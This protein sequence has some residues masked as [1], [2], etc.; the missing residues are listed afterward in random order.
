MVK[1]L[2]NATGFTLPPGSQDGDLLFVQSNALQR[3][4]IGTSG[5]NLRVVSN[6]PNW[7]EALDTILSI[8]S[9]AT[10]DLFYKSANGYARLGV[11]S[12]GQVLTLAGGLPSWAS[13]ATASGDMQGTPIFITSTGQILT[14][15]RYSVVTVANATVVLP[16]VSTIGW[17]IVVNASTTAI[18]IS[19]TGTDLHNRLIPSFGVGFIYTNAALTDYIGNFN[20]ST[21]TT[22]TVSYPYTGSDTAIPVPS[23]ATVSGFK[24]WAS[25]GGGSAYSSLDNVCRGGAG[26]YVGFDIAVAGSENLIGRVGQGGY[27]RE[28]NLGVRTYCGGGIPTSIESIFTGSG[29]GFTALYR[30]STLLGIAGAGAGGNG[31]A[32][33]RNGGAGGTT[34]GGIGSGAGSGAGGTQSAGGAINGV[35][36]LGGNSTQPY[37]G[38]GGAGFFG[39]GAATA[40]GGAGA[41]GSSWITP[42]ATNTVQAAGSGFTPGNNAD[43]AYVAGVGVGGL[44]TNDGL[45]TAIGGNGLLVVTHRSV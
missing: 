39:G 44:G 11:G 9:Q 23:W 8:P 38:A 18:V 4:A 1:I 10:G 5:Q 42:G 14:R 32:D 17:F 37:G 7:A 35:S 6:L 34:T 16:T 22:Q 45:G 20:V 28:N 15:N 43:P 27:S 36:L 33:A 19:A 29:G 25:A 13:P 12:T 26:A 3:R 2:R 24:L 30:G 31:A 40:D 21:A 41:G